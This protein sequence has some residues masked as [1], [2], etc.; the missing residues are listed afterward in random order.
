MDS[1]LIIAGENSGEKYGADLVHQFKKLHPSLSFFGIGGKHMEREGVNLLF[2]VEELAVVGVFEIIS[3]LPRIKKIFNKIKREIKRQK[4]SAAVLIDSP[5][6]NLRLAKK[7]KKLSIPVLYYISP[8]VWAWRKGRLKTI[9]KTVDKMMLIFPFE[10]KIYED[11][12]I[13]AVYVGHPLKERVKTSLTKNEFLEKHGLSGQKKLISL[14]PGSRRSELKYHIPVLAEAM[15]RIKSEW[16]T[17][18]VLLLAENLEKNFLLS[19]IPPWLKGLKILSEDHYE[20]IASSDLVLS[21]CGT[22]N[23]EAALLETPLV[24]FYRISPLTYFF[25]HRLAT[26]KNFSIVNILAGERII[27]ELIQRDFTPQ[28]IFEEIKKIFDSEEQ[29][30]G[31]ITQFRRIKKLLGDKTAPQNA[32]QELGKLIKQKQDTA[33][34]QLESK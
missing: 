18:F 4:P 6:F 19:L 30:S 24:S 17:Q 9:K 26:I 8:T 3:H 34:R 10:E 33:K 32:A 15:D 1:I 27:P 29:R 12:G 20:A 14:L 22:A 13:P 23:L 21:A 16:D 28:N 25:G 11:Y 2:P 5:D 7:L 31:M